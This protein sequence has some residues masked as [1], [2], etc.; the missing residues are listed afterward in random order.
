MEKPTV[1]L[2]VKLTGRGPKGAWTHILIPFNAEEAFGRRG[3]IPV[4]GTINGHAFRSSLMPE[5]E[6]RHYLAAN[7][8]MLAGAS[9]VA[10]ETV[11]LVLALDTAERIVEPPAELAAALKS[12]PQAKAAFERL[13]YSHRKEYA[14]WVAG[15]KKPETRESRAQKAV[16][17]IVA[18]KRRS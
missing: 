18:G 8:T 16:E 14:D 11:H 4:A 3:L 6:G 5:G 7:K 10:G 2:D 15:G 1:K 13:S 12:H 17:M 9:A